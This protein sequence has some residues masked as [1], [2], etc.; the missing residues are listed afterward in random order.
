MTDPINRESVQDVLGPV[1]DSLAFEL[2]AT[3]ATEP[4]LREAATW[5]VNDEA[6]ANE[7]RSLPSGRIA[8]LVE[9]LDRHEAPVNLS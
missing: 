5:F 9:I 7:L 3:G 1:D 2:I 4:E 8:Q 6:L